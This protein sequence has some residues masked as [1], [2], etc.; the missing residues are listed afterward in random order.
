MYCCSDW[1][2]LKHILC[3]CW[4]PAPN[5]CAY[6]DNS[7]SSTPAQQG[8]QASESILGESDSTFF[9][10]LLVISFAGVSC[11]AS[12]AWTAHVVYNCLSIC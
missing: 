9:V 8:A 2:M 10:K 6:A 11:I 3:P 12:H 7:N 1:S 4:T 5:C